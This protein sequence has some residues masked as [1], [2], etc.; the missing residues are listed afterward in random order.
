MSIFAECRN[1][2]PALSR[3]VNGRPAVYFDG[4]A[5]SQ[6][7]RRVVEAISYSPN[8]W[9]LETTDGGL[10]AALDAAN[11]LYEGD[12]VVFATP[13]IGKRHQ[14]KV[15]NDPLFIDQWHLENTGQ[16][17]GVAGSFDRVVVL[18]SRA[19]TRELSVAS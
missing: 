6:V 8:T 4:P 9:T 5:G 2:F 11:M 16:S 1:E 19:G 18:D 10:T 3:I 14:R 13:L 7:P 17:G 15:I 12:G